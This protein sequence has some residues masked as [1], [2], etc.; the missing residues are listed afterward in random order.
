MSTFKLNNCCRKQIFCDK[1]I[2]MKTRRC[3]FFTS[4][5]IISNVTTPHAER[6]IQ[7]QTEAQL[8]YAH[9][10][11]KAARLLFKCF[12][13]TVCFAMRGITHNPPQKDVAWL[14]I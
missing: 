5:F 11:E 1:V 12:Y 13:C 6:S 9:T 14:R 10:E 7:I 8:E 4:P 3:P 2:H